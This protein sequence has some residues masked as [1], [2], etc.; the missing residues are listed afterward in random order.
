VVFR[1]VERLLI[2]IGGVTTIVM[3]TLLYRWGVRRPQQLEAAGSGFSFALKNAAPG[4]VLALFGMSVLLVGLSRPLDVRTSE[5]SYSPATEDPTGPSGKQGAVS[6]NYH[7]GTDRAL[8]EL[9]RIATL[10][11][12]PSDRAHEE[13]ENS[14]CIAN[15]ALSLLE[16]PAELTQFF[17]DVREASDTADPAVSLARLSQRARQVKLTLRPKASSQ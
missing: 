7:S 4:S 17:Q 9:D 16:L 8:Q 11:A 6:V 12:L 15:G 5:S 1:G 13:L 10:P 2:E 3:G 14:K